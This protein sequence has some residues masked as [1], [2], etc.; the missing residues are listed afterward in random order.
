MIERRD[1]AQDVG[2]E[3]LPVVV[4]LKD[5][6]PLLVDG[7]LTAD[8]FPKKIQA[9]AMTITAPT[10]P[11]WRCGRVSVSRMSIGKSSKLSKVVKA[12]QR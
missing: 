7:T 8:R 10:I 4:R 2:E 9:S 12:L 6:P 3:G 1:L 5:I 11:N